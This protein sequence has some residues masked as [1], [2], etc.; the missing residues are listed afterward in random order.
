MEIMRMKSQLCAWTSMSAARGLIPVT[1]MPS[2]SMNQ[3]PLLASAKP[4]TLE[5]EVIVKVSME[6]VPVQNLSGSEEYHLRGHGAV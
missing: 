3:G 2:V 1:S 4:D 5:M 6:V